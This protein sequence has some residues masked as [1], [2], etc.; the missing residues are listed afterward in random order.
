MKH[1][2]A[3]RLWALCRKETYQIIRDPSSILVAFIMPVL[4]LFVLGYAVNLDA[5]HLRLGLL[6]EEGGA[7]A[8]GFEQALR[9]SSA[10]AVQQGTSRAQLLA[11]LEEGNLL[12]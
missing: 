6:R 3:R 12:V 5:N 1:L 9:A 8:I 10:F 4:L 11:Q 7:P 2:S